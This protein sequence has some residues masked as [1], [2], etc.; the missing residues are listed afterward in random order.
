MKILITG[1]CGFIGSNFV[2]YMIKT[3]PDY[4]LVNLDKL[5]YAGNPENLKDLE[6]NPNYEFIKGDI[7]DKELVEKIAKDCDAIINFAAETHVDRSIGDPESFIKTDIFGTHNLLEAA[8]KFNLKF[9]QISTDEVYGSIEKGSFTED[10]TLN[11]SSPYSASKTGADVLVRSYFVTYGMHVMIT[12]SSNNYG[13]Y[14]YPEKL[15]PLFVTNAMEGKQ[16]PIY[17]D[18]KQ[19]RDWLFVE[20]N[21]SAIATVF[22]K[23]K[24]GEV[25]NIGAD[26]EKTN[27]EITKTI[28]KKLGKTEELIQYVKDRPGHDQRYSVDSSKTK[29]LGWK[30]THSFEDAMELTVNWYKNNQ[31][32]WTPLKSGEFID[33]YKKH[34]NETHGLK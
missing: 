2:R 31:E 11:P 15:I 29:S 9:L 6:S 8:R 10:S 24:P 34:Y 22:H 32:W 33:Y 23:G 21:C 28:L 26:S 27:M 20:D 3:Y 1:G 12:R 30:P 4:K 16:L 18:G 7:C 14:Q 5:T 19:V 17:G 13:P 25:Y